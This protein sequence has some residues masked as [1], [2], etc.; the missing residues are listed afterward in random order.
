MSEVQQLKTN[1]LAKFN[2]EKVEEKNRKNKKSADVFY[3]RMFISISKSPPFLISFISPNPI[4]WA[5]L[6]FHYIIPS[7]ESPLMSMNKF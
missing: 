6:E 1:V 4:S 3:E 5:R 7:G 2:L